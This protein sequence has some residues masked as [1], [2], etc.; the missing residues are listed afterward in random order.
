VSRYAPYFVLATRIDFLFACNL[1]SSASLWVYA[2]LSSEV[3]W[4]RSAA[5]PLTWPIS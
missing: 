4:C 3:S 2:V 1:S 5:R